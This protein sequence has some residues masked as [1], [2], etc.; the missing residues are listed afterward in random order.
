MFD[1]KVLDNKNFLR[2]QAQKEMLFVTYLPISVEVSLTSDV[3]TKL[4]NINL[5]WGFSLMSFVSL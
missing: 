4:R 3:F 2:L 1:I 5:N